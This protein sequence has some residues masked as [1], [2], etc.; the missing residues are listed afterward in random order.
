[1]EPAFLGLVLDSSVLVAAERRKLTTPEAIKQIRKVI[2]D[3]PIVICALAVAELATASI[4]PIRRSV[5][6]SGVSSSTNSKHKSQSIRS[7]RPLRKSW[8][9]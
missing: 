3:V 9:A 5:A 4:V 6:A 1:M 8:R 7:L 2:S